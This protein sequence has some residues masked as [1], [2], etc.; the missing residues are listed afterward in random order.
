MKNINLFVLLFT[1][2]LTTSLFSQSEQVNI[3]FQDATAAKQLKIDIPMGEIRIK[4]TNRKDIL[5]RYETSEEEEE[6]QDETSVEKN[7]GLKKIAGSN[8]N[9][10]MTCS[11]NVATIR[12]SN[13]YRYLI[14]DIEVPQN[15][16]L[17]IQKNIGDTVW[18]SNISGNVNIEINVGDI[19]AEGIKG[20]VNALFLKMRRFLLVFTLLLLVPKTRLVVSL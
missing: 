12:A 8:L 13:W 11:E 3:P 6:Q 19:I 16:A 10:E 9:L 1:L 18:V 14:L 2:L 5:V 7:K 20:L 15:I 17:D 4:G